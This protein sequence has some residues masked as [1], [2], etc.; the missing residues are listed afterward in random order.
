MMNDI[1]ELKSFRMVRLAIEGDPFFQQTDGGQLTL[2]TGYDLLI[3]NDLPRLFMLILRVGGTVEG[4]PVPLRFDLRIAGEFVVPESVEADKRGGLVAYNGGMILY[5]M[6]RGQVAMATGSFGMGS[7]LLPTIN[8]A[9]TIRQVEEKRAANASPA[10]EVST[11]PAKRKSVAA[12]PK[13]AAK[14]SPKTKTKKRT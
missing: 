9:E 2:E 14:P 3:N 12:S 13:A 4:T 11:K 6:L 1:L 5:G 8:W 7:L 10:P